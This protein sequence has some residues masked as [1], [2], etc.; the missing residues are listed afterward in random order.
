[1]VWNYQ[2]ADNTADCS[3]KKIIFFV[4]FIII[5]R[6]RSFAMASILQFW[7]AV[8]ITMIT[9]YFSAVFN[10]H[11]DF[12]TSTGVDNDIVRRGS[13]PGPILACIITQSVHY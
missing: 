6:T 5:F 8:N 12:L 2:N 1:M 11:S 7:A 4:S 9:Y 13:L 3:L 10:S